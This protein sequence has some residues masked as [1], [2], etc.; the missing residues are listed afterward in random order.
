M[1]QRMIRMPETP[2]KAVFFCLFIHKCFSANINGSLVLIDKINALK[3]CFAKYQN[4]YL[5][6]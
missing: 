3:I 4:R 1:T 5:K 6:V 2:A